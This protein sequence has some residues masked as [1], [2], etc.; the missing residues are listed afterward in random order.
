MNYPFK[1]IM[2][3]NGLNELESISFMR[4]HPVYSQDALGAGQRWRDL[5]AGWLKH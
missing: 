3:L 5:T 2:G 1:R 4:R